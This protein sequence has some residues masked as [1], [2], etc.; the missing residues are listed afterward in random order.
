LF[1]L[2][3][4]QAAGLGFVCQFD[5]GEGCMESGCILDLPE[6]QCGNITRQA[7][8]R[9]PSVTTRAKPLCQPLVRVN[10]GTRKAQG[11]HLDKNPDR[12]SLIGGKFRWG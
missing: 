12:P 9:M 10:P 11:R 7:A 5:L 1:A 3:V 8:R 6:I 2:I 4:F